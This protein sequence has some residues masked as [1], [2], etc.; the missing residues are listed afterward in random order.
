MKQSFVMR[1]G[2]RSVEKWVPISA[3]HFCKFLRAKIG[4]VGVARLSHLNRRPI[5]KKTL[6]NSSS[7]SS[8]CIELPADHFLT[9]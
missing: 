5:F 3:E 9:Y 7:A 4:G 8:L 6:D 2:C 1:S